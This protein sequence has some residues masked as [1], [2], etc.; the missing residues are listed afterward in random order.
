MMNSLVALDMPAS[1]DF[2]SALKSIWDSGD[3]ALPIDQ[4][5]PQHARRKLVEQ[6]SASAVIEGDNLRTNL[7]GG[8]PVEQGDALVIATS[9]STG[10]PKGV[11][12]THGSI[13]AAILTTGGRLNCSSHD[14]WLACLS[15]AHVGGL[16]V[17][18][19]ALH[20]KSS[21]TV[22]SRADQKTFL[23]ALAKGATMTSLVPTV[24][25]SVDI[26]KF[27][28]VLI[29]GAQ[30]PGELPS[31]AI[32]TFGL[33]ETMGGVVYDGVPLDGVEVRITD[34]S[35]ILIRSRTLLRC[36]RD[37]T[38]PTTKDGW[39]PT[40]DLGE[41]TDRR[42]SV[43]GRRD[44]LINTGGYKVWPRTVENSITTIGGVADCVVRGLTDEKWGSMVSAWIVLADPKVR[45]NLD[46]VRRHI[47][48][49][50]P[51]YCAPN[52][53][54]IVDQIPRST[55]GKVQVSELLKLKTV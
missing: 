45:L 52:K 27:R 7:S 39:L 43:H 6:F 46:D 3:A 54:F 11:V 50:L 5:L 49:S 28:T 33:T 34:D 22:S 41:I 53:I 29:G 18:L 51:D 12:H 24:L 30:A 8:V 10:E 26:S 2:V 23:A 48:Q 44:E 38:N 40:G 47:K 25:Q 36:Y 16:S 1:Q 4:R 9:G 15:L 31:N 42:L 19:R 13:E 32:S 14:H 55:L 37:G 35:E 17:V 20:F 21:L